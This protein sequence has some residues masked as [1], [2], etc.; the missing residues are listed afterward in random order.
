MLEQP[1][2]RNQVQFLLKTSRT[3]P[4]EPLEENY[5]RQVLKRLR[6]QG[7]KLVEVFVLSA[8][9]DIDR[10]QERTRRKLGSNAIAS[11]TWL[12][13]TASAGDWTDGRYIPEPMEAIDDMEPQPEAVVLVL[14]GA[15]GDP[16]STVDQLQ[17]MTANT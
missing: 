6:H 5:A 16:D 13:E 3:D 11:R 9:G 8:A 10:Y 2:W 14:M 17:G 15:E 7:R 4:A 1:S 12:C